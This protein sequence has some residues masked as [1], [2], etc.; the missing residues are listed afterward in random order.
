[1]QETQMEKP[2]AIV[3]LRIVLT[4]TEPAMLSPYGSFSEVEI[5]AVYGATSEF[6]HTASLVAEL[7][8]QKKPWL[9]QV[10]F[11]LNCTVASRYAC[12]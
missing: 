7:L 3:S 4:P 12:S 11:C 1:M 10:N 8:E 5:S 9:Y 2:R 6:S